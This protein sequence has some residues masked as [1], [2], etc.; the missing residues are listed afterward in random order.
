MHFHWLN[1]EF[2]HD[3][4]THTHTTQCQPDKNDYLLFLSPQVHCSV[5]KAVWLV[6]SI[7]YAWTMAFFFLFISLASSFAC[8]ARKTACDA[9]CKPWFGSR[10]KHFSFFFLATISVCV[11]N[12][13]W[14]GEEKDIWTV[15]AIMQQF[16]GSVGCG[17]LLKLFISS[18]LPCICWALLAKLGQ[19]F[20]S[21]RSE[22]YAKNA[23]NEQ[24]KFPSPET[25][26]GRES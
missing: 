8:F 10:F 6:W 17:S 13:R 1:A 11:C 2:L 7:L 26:T 15:V 18:C 16:V 14:F 22:I 9:S 19:T 25:K 4:H 5:D 3:S 23:K 12:V 21:I 20:H 24:T